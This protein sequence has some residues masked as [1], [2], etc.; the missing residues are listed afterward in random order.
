MAETQSNA[1]QNEGPDELD[2]LVMIGGAGGEHPPPISLRILAAPS[3]ED[4]FNTL[5]L[6]LAPVACVLLKDS[7]FEF[8]SSFVG[9]RVFVQMKYLARLRERRPGIVASIF[10]H[11]DPV[12]DDTYNKK[13]SGRRAQAVYGLLTRRVDLWEEIFSEPQGGDKWGDSAIKTMLQTLGHGKQEGDEGDG[14]LKKAIKE[15]QGENG[16][17][18]DG[19]AGP[20]T[21]KKLFKAYMDAICVDKSGEPFQLDEKKDFLARGEDKDGKGD[22]QGCSEFNPVLLFSKAQKAEFDQAQDKTDRNAANK[23]NRRVMIFLFREGLK[24]LPSKW[25]CPRAKDG[26]DG[27]KKRFFSDGEKRRTN[28][29]EEREYKATKDTFACRFY[30][31]F[32]HES[33]CETGA[34]SGL[35][36]H[37]SLLLR[38][39]SGCVPIAKKKYKVT[40]APDRILEGTTDDKGLVQHPDIP[41]GDYKLEVDGHT[42]FVPA[43]PTFREPR[44]H[45][46]HDYFLFEDGDLERAV[47]DGPEQTDD[48]N[49]PE[50]IAEGRVTDDI[51]EEDSGEAIV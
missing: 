43:T 46:V 51:P 33:P 12:G 13:L 31:R 50:Q 19:I 9:P 14:D 37:L 27:C 21:R 16:L 47:A 35:K 39:N 10:G 26:I 42:T 41:P 48:L 15:F 45:Q 25:P 2:H 8:D 18:E 20:N 40:I 11:A 22:Y 7:R 1:M 49:P 38:S 17:T 5:R 3:L 6:P 30:D 28:T 24:V 29:A 34:D 4:E 36:C 44:E 32:A 23:P